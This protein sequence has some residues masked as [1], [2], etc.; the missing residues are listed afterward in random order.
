M[1]FVI[2]FLLRERLWLGLTLVTVL[3]SAAL[4]LAQAGL[5]SQ[6]ATLL[7]RLNEKRVAPVTAVAP[8]PRHGGTFFEKTIEIVKVWR[9]EGNRAGMERVIAEE[10]AFFILLFGGMALVVVLFLNLFNYLKD[11]SAGYLAVRV[12]TRIRQRLFEHVLTLPSPFFKSHASGDL[13]ARSLAD[14]Q[15]IQQELCSAFEMV[16]LA[17]IMLISGLGVLFAMNRDFALILLG[18]GVAAV[19]VMQLAL[20]ALKRIIHAAQSRLADLTRLLQ[21]VTYAIDIVKIYGREPFERG[22]Y[23]TTVARFLVRSLQEHALV[24]LVRPL[25]EFLGALAI[26]VIVL[27]GASRIWAGGMTLDEILHFIIF[28]IVISPFVYKFANIFVMRQRIRVASER[29]KEVFDRQGELSPIPGPRP[30]RLDGSVVFDK[31]CFK[32]PGAN[33]PA[34]WNVSFETTANQEIALV[35]P[36]GSGKSTVISLLPALLRPDSG[37]ILFDGHDS[38]ELSLAE[39]RGAMALVSQETLLFPA[40]FRENIRYGRLEASHGEIEEAARVAGLHEFILSRP[41]GYETLIGERGMQLSG[42][43]RQRMTIARAVLKN[44][45]ILLLDEATSALDSESE[46]QVQDALEPLMRRQTTF[47]VAHRLSTILGAD[48]IL[49]FED[50][51]IAEEGTSEFLL[52]KDGLFA[53]LWRHQAGASQGL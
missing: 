14:I 48:R 18:V 9:A 10:S 28:L 15:L 21:Q 26:I 27:Y 52:A 37:R 12:A 6:F 5:F 44:P 17:P 20:A 22:R 16:L 13:V 24:R 8:A 23:A 29:L 33:R 31:V 3:L 43:Q 42:G 41:Q 34:L 25:T 7:V 1:K 51:E 32:Y 53:R 50:G 46:R 40:S 36:S 11:L 38:R 19:L 49:V 35:G 4:T 45:R 47:V 2:S 30:V 39:L